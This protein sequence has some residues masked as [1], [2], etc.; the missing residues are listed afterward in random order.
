MSI[1]TAFS[2]LNNKLDNA[3]ENLAEV[4]LST[5]FRLV[6]FIATVA[7]AYFDVFNVLDSKDFEPAS[8]F[9][10]Y[11]LAAFFLYLFSLLIL[12]MLSKSVDE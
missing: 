11:A 3:V 5:L 6:Y 12:A 9:V 1:T 4:L 7:C 8:A 10:A 2:N